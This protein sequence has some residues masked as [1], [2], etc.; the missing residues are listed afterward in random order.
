MPC[1]RKHG[2]RDLLHE[3]L[4][5]LQFAGFQQIPASRPRRAQESPAPPPWRTCCPSLRRRRH[6]S[7]FF[8][9][10]PVTLPPAAS[11]QCLGLFARDARQRSGE[12]EGHARLAPARLGLRRASCAGCT[13][14]AQQP[15]DNVAIVRLGEERAMLCATTGPDVRAP[16]AAAGSS[17]SISASSDRSPAPDRGQCSRRRCGSPARRRSAPGVGCLLL[18]MAATD[19]AADFSPMCSSPASRSASRRYT[20]A[21]VLTRSC[22]DELVDELVAQALDIHRPPRSE[23]QQRLLAL[24]R[25]HQPAGAAG[26]RLALLPHHQP[27]PHSGHLLGITNARACAGRLSSSTRT[28]SGITSPARRTITKSPTCTSLRRTSSSLCRVALV[29]VTPP[30]NTGFSR[31]TGVSAPVRP[32]CTSMSSTSVPASSAANLWATRSA[33]R[34]TRSPAAPAA[35]DR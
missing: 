32:T 2:F 7:V 22:V 25:A 29:T 15:G 10:L 28:T 35:R 11:I 13:P 16:A 18:S 33:A 34:A 23:M 24:G 17:A 4:R 3:C 31:A 26:H 14:A 12:H 9:T 1:D 30:T 20:S 27:T 19:L 5:W 21:G 6:S 8:D